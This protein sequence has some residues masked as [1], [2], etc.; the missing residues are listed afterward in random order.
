MLF[1]QERTETLWQA[2]RPRLAALG[3]KGLAARNTFINQMLDSFSEKLDAAEA[4]PFQGEVM[5][6]S[7]VILSRDAGLE[8]FV[9]RCYLRLTTTHNRSGSDSPNSAEAG[10]E[11]GLALSIH[12][13][14]AGG[15]GG[16]QPRQLGWNG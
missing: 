11:A 3:E 12:P 10:R 16:G 8:D 5:P 1:L 6:S 15:G 4:A 7:A 9:N 13:P 14:V 2:N